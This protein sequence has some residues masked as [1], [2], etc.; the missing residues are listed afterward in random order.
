MVV[1][2]SEDPLG[3][4]VCQRRG[5]R[6]GSGKVFGLVGGAGERLFGLSERGVRR[7]QAWALALVNMDRAGAVGARL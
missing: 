5:R 1:G 6:S 7:C 2:R 3:P 4:G